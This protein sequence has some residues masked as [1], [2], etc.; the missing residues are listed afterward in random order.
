MPP[1]LVFLE[2]KLDIPLLDR[3]PE[4]PPHKRGRRLHVLAGPV[5]DMKCAIDTRYRGRNIGLHAAELAD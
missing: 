3:I 1:P 5:L 2:D 4:A